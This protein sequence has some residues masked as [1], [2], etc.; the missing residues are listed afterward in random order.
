MQV[1]TNDISSTKIRLLLKR[2]MTIDYL[3]VSP[4]HNFS[5]PSNI[6][7][8]PDDV[9]NYIYE[10]N[11]YRDGD[12]F[13]GTKDTDIGSSNNALDGASTS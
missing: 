2:N 7:R 13:N 4:Q 8:I 9:I 10:H 6:C 5:N 11:L 12:I 1:I 3:F